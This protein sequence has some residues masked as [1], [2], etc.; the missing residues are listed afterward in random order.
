MDIDVTYIFQFGLFLV[1]LVGLN[2]IILKPVL[3][4]ILEREQKIEGARDEVQLLTKLGDEDMEKYQDRM[5]GARQKAQQAREAL[6]NEGRE[7]ERTMLA[8][9]RA[10]IAEKLNRTRTQ[11]GDAED[12]A[13]GQLAQESEALS[14]QLAEKILGREVAA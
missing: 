9:V 6:T 12:K 5:R 3:S 10:Q 7:T 1:V 8:D 14:R 13:R 2:G 4:I 11:V